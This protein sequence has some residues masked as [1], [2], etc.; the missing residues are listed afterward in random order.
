MSHNGC[1][2]WE[3]GENL[4]TSQCT[5]LVASAA[6]SVCHWRPG[7]FPKSSKSLGH[8][9]KSKKLQSRS[10]KEDGGSSYTDD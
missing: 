1:L 7:G 5:R 4:P 10:V 6:S 8:N 2:A 3:M 9:G